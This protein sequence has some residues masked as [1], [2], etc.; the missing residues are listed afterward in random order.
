M[1]FQLLAAAAVLLSASLVAHADTDTDTDTNFSFTDVSVQGGGSIT[2]YI[3]IDTTTGTAVGSD[4]TIDST[5]GVTLPSRPPSRRGEARVATTTL[6]SSTTTC[7]G[8]LS[9]LCSTRAPLRATQEGLNNESNFL[10]SDYDE[11]SFTAV[12]T[13]SPPL[14]RS[15]RAWFCSGPAH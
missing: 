6:W 14:R 3:T 5:I 1:R 13:P 15:H 12:L 7:S 8:T 11:P 10:N 2:G 9:R 4:F